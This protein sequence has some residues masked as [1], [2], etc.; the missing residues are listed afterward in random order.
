[1][2]NR[3]RKRGCCKVPAENITLCHPITN[4]PDNNI[5]THKRNEQNSEGDKKNLKRQKQL[6]NLKS[7]HV[8]PTCCNFGPNRDLKWPGFFFCNACSLWD[9]RQKDN[10]CLKRSMKKYTCTANHT[11]FLKPT[12][13]LKKGYYEKSMVMTNIDKKVSQPKYPPKQENTESKTER[14]KILEERVSK[15]NKR[16]ASIEDKVTQKNDLI[17]ELRK[18]RKRQCRK[19]SKLESKICS[20]NL[21]EKR[22][23]ILESIEYSIEAVLNRH[24]CRYGARR[25]GEAIAKA[26]WNVRDGVARSG[27]MTIARTHLRENVFNPQNILKAM[28]LAGGTCNLAA[29]TVIRSVELAANDPYCMRAKKHSI[30]P[31]EYNIRQASK[32]VHKF[33]DIIIPMQHYVSENG[34]CVEFCDIVDVVKKL[35]H[36]FGLSKVAKQ[37]AIDLALTLDGS[38]LTSKLSFVMAG[39]KLIDLAVKNPQTGKYELDPSFEEDYCVQSR[40]WCF[41]AKIC[42]GKE[43]KKMYQEEFKSLFDTFIEASEEGQDVFEGWKPINF[44][45]PADMA[46][47]QKVLGI[48]GAAKVYKFFC[49][50][51]S[52]TS[53]EIVTP[54]EGDNICGRCREKQTVNPDWKCLHQEFASE[55]E[56]KKYNDALDHLK[57]SWTHDMEPVRKEGKLRLGPENDLKSVFFI[58][59]TIEETMS[60]SSLL[61]KEMRLRNKSTLRK[62]LEQMQEELKQCLE[63][64]KRMDELMKLICESSTRKEAMARI[65]T[66]VPCIMHCE[67]RVG[68]KLLTM[69]LI[70]GLSNFQGANFAHLASTRSQKE[71]EQLFVESIEKEIS[72]NILGSYGNEAQWNLPVERRSNGDDSSLFIGTINMENYKVRKIID[73]IENIIETCIPEVEKKRKY[74][75]CLKHY[76]ETM[77]ILR[78]KDG[79]Y[80]EEEIINF[81]EHADQFFQTWVDMHGMQGV[82]N[83]IHM[84]GVGHFTEYMRRWGNLHKYSQQGWEALNALM[85]LFFFR[86]TNKGGKNS[87]ENVTSYKSKLVPLGRLIQRRMV[88]VCNLLPVDLFDTSYVFP[89]QDNTDDNLVINNEDDDNNNDIIFDTTNI[90][91]T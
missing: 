72:G 34:E 14:I 5:L 51:C 56:T 86:R 3:C 42:M 61:T 58:P 22:D 33:C 16:I 44:S 31:H 60:F 71:R 27:M 30:L 67:N 17:D 66:F 54:N 48:G 88:W 20:I 74:R 24:Y 47:I 10:N 55:E 38:N 29:Y 39:I 49:H 28:D 83:Y 63:V 65:I 12:H 76:N 26:C 73:N 4:E 18:E 91:E 40:K 79:D 59:N 52:I 81:E 82:T 41:P 15:L 43:T 25:V 11:S 80:T 9:N 2:S 75:F 1:M 23:N 87:G 77:K 32:L 6:E 50:C 90:V 45:N 53:A 62:T 35:C 57:S 64:E 21:E 69:L 36:A 78:K 19:I 70:E 85:K 84:I 13:L 8:K 89:D 46:A 7:D 37:R 68:I